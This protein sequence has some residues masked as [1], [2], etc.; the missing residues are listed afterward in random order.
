MVSL[1]LKSRDIIPFPF[2]SWTVFP[3]FLT[4]GCLTE[5]IDDNF[6]V[7]GSWLYSGRNTTGE[8][9]LGFTRDDQRF[10]GSRVLTSRWFGAY[11]LEWRPGDQLFFKGGLNLNHLRPNVDAYDHGISETRNDLFASGVWQ[12]S[13]RLRVGVN[14][15]QPMVEGNLKP[16]SPS[17]SA[18][19]VIMEME[20]AE[21]KGQAEVSRSFRIPTLNDRYWIPGSYTYEQ[22]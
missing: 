5:T 17:V 6:R 1:Y 13:T 8:L 2:H 19:W 12:P 14:L 20:K 7:L 4:I 9:S 16:F 15:R 22:T 18:E 3:G 10:N 21:L 11:Q